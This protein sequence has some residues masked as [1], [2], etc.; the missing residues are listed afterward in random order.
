[1]A[2]DARVRLRYMNEC[3]IFHNTHSITF[4]LYTF[5]IYFSSSF[6]RTFYIKS[7]NIMS[8]YSSKNCFKFELTLCHLLS[9]YILQTTPYGAK[10]KMTF[11]IGCDVSKQTLTLTRTRRHFPA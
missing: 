11:A 9:S 6:S 5:Y 2:K 3:R 8:A 1:M 4:L 7:Q 10:V